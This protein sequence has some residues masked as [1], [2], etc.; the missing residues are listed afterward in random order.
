MNDR[1]KREKAAYDESDIFE[2]SYELPLYKVQIE[3]V[4]RLFGMTDN[5]FLNL[6]TTP[7][8]MLNS[9]LSVKPDNLILRVCNRIDLSLLKTRI[10][11][12]MRSAYLVWIKK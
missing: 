12:W 1:V 2:E 10:K 5:F 4:D 3:Y 7:F 11:Y 9:R 6:V 8:A